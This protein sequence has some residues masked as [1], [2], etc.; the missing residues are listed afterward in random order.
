M[1]EDRSGI[2][3]LRTAIDDVATEI[4]DR[5]TAR[6]R[7]RH[8]WALGVAMAA[9]VVLIALLIGTWTLRPSPVAESSEVKVLVLKINGR[10]VRARIVD[11][12][13]PA[14]IIVMPQSDR[15]APPAAASVL[16]GG[17]R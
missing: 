5:G 3:K 6:S 2:E 16:I 10:E 13:A 4:E 7:T 17:A 14:T 1:N 11:D 8:G 15:G 9:A 12:S